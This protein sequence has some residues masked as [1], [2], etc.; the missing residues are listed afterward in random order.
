MNKVF[1][2]TDPK[3]IS[4]YIASEV[5]GYLECMG[6]TD[7]VLIDNPALIVDYLTLVV[8]YLVKI[9]PRSDHTID[10]MCKLMGASYFEEGRR[11]P[12]WAIISEI[13]ATYK[14]DPVFADGAN[15]EEEITNEDIDQCFEF[16]EYEIIF[17]DDDKQQD[18]HLGMISV[19]KVKY[20]R[21]ARPPKLSKER[22]NIGKGRDNVYRQQFKRFLEIMTPESIKMYLDRYVVGQDET[23]KILSTAV[24]NHYLRL[25]YPEAKIIKTNILMVGPTG[26]GKTE[27][28]RR[29][30]NLVSVPVVVTDFSGI[31]ATPWKG[32]NKEEALT[33]LYE[34]AGRNLEMAQSGIVF[35][36]E[37]D[38]IVP[39]K[40]YSRGGD[41]NDELQG[42]LLGML[43]GTELDVPAGGSSIIRMDTSNILFVCAGAFE[44]LDKIVEKDI[45]KSGI[46][47]GS[48]VKKPEGFQLTR[49]NLDQKH[50]IKYG[51]KP[52]LAG[53]LH[54]VG[55]LNKL[56]REQLKC[57]LTEADDNVIKRYENEFREEEDVK[58][59]FTDEALDVII[60]KVLNMDIGARGLNS[61]I[62]DILKVPL[63]EVPSDR[64]IRE[65]TVTGAAARGEGKPEYSY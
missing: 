50:L 14:N 35:C 9:R 38:K 56:T 42:Q 32:R 4:D 29:I 33:T 7:G 12:F 11:T 25:A 52:E 15:L 54:T 49:D 6:D 26:S 41:I 58:L 13:S 62:H 53:R 39:A 23:K 17:V 48:E 31:V 27:M 36:D 28:I 44:G 10:S 18:S 3:E 61:V 5:R 22:L 19:C 43:E 59:T 21:S 20:N 24:Y 30:S 47:F 37:F 2:K 63:F 57:I 40:R 55:V 65:V 64:N 34:R 60:E 16:I 1:S 8:Y 45:G 46:G 51:M